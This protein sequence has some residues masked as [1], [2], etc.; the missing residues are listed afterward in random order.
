MHLQATLKSQNSSL[1]GSFFFWD[2]HAVQ[3]N[4]RILNYRKT[5]FNR[6]TIISENTGAQE[7][8]LAIKSGVKRK[9]SWRC[10]TPSVNYWTLQPQPLQ[11]WMEVRFSLDSICRNATLHWTD[12]GGIPACVL[13]YCHRHFSAPF[14]PLM[15]QWH[16]IAVY[17]HVYTQDSGIEWHCLTKPLT[18]LVRDY[19]G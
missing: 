19:I 12:S 11:H 6:A 13:D 1:A 8:S 5:G 17:N 9:H 2:I 14:V 10:V 3:Y 7:H 4:K 15:T 18:R 16:Y